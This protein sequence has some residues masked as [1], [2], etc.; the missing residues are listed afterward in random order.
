MVEF[1]K[2]QLNDEN[3]IEN[4]VIATDFNACMDVVSQKISA[5]NSDNPFS[6][7]IFVVLK[8]RIKQP[9]QS[10]STLSQT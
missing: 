4:L 7:I 3:R 1:G 10:L 5:L 8:H 6:V 2:W 9:W